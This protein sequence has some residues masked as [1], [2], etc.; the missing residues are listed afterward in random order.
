MA[1][2]T[3]VPTAPTVKRFRRRGSVRRTRSRAKEGVACRLDAEVPDSTAADQEPE[4]PCVKR[5]GRHAKPGEAGNDSE[6]VA[7]KERAERSANCS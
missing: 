5:R 3:S 6:L 1:M 4:R 7:E 2:P